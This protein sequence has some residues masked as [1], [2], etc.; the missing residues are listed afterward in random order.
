M[1]RIIA[2]Y[3][4]TIIRAYCRI[5]F[6]I[7]RIRFLEELDQYIPSTGRVLDLGCGFG[8]FSLFFASSVPSRRLLGVDLNQRR[9]SMAKRSADR[10][11]LGNVEFVEADADDAKLPPELAC[12][13]MLDLLHHLPETKVAPLLS[14]VHGALVT[15]GTLLIKDVDT[16]PFYKR[17]FT[18]WLDRLMVGMEPI[19]YWSAEEMIDMLEDQ[20][21]TVY[22]HELRDILPYPHRL[23]ICRKQTARADEISAGRVQ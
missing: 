2:S 9:I 22:S 5:R 23:Y 6:I 17:W 12:V 20:G 18:L 10:L 21:F 14:R 7:M 8:L 16:R 13:Y 19:R 11:R 15:G 4:S 1:K 3:D